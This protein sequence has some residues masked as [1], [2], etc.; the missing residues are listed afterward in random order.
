MNIDSIFISKQAELTKF[1]SEKEYQL[2][3]RQKT[4]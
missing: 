1:K 2:N 4:K 3:K